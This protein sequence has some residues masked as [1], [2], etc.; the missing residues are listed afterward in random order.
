MLLD[1]HG[2]RPYVD[3]IGQE[4]N[5]KMSKHPLTSVNPTHLKRA[6][7][8]AILVKKFKK[9]LKYNGNLGHCDDFWQ[10]LTETGHDIISTN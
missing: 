2:I 5:E 6:F 4:H 3:G 8:N 1:A 9:G 7:D 10:C